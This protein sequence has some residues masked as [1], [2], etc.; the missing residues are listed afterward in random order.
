MS[1]RNRQLNL[2]PYFIEI[3]P[4]PE[5]RNKMIHAHADI[6]IRT[7]SFMG[8]LEVLAL[9]SVYYTEEQLRALDK[10]LYIDQIAVDVL[11]QNP[12]E[13][14]IR[15]SLINTL[16]PN[17]TPEKASPPTSFNIHGFECVIK[18]HQAHLRLRD[19]GFDIV[20]IERMQ[21]LGRFISS[22]NTETTIS[23][24]V[25][26]VVFRD[27]ATE[28]LHLSTT[29]MNLVLTVLAQESMSSKSLSMLYRLDDIIN[30]FVMKGFEWGTRMGLIA[31]LSKE[32]EVVIEDTSFLS[33]IHAQ[34][35]KSKELVV[36]GEIARPSSSVSSSSSF[37]GRS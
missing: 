5:Q 32:E 25:L 3:T 20:E 24:E 29:S 11:L 7:A 33:K 17:A 37:I 22:F 16:D 12:T 4:D 35:V 27:Y 2:L 19:L 18:F 1:V 21:E 34:A 28:S 6:A 10:H 13:E 9:L 26:P 31:K 14:E 36:S 30:S 8:N 23:E 15:K